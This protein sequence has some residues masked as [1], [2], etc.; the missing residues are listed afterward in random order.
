MRDATTDEQME[1]VQNT[2]PPN[3]PEVPVMQQAAAEREAESLPLPAITQQDYDRVVQEREQLLDRL[4]RLQ[5]E[6]DNYRK[7]EARERAEFRDVAMAK[8]IEPLLQPLDNFYLALKAQ[9]TPEQFR[10]GVELIARQMEEALR[11]LGVQPIE[12]V[13]AQFDP[14]LHE[15]LG[16]VETK[17]APDHQ[18]VDEVRRGY[19]LRDRLLR[20]ALVRVASNPTS[21]E[22]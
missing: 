11:S 1:A 14:H 7:R 13:G 3:D 4:A 16:Q 18:V 22:A 6:F 17:E 19:K 10:A 8:V 2:D 5:A 15:A 12:A 9:G 21:K 20:P